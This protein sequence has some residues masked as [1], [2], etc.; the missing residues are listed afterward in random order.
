MINQV[1]S[2]CQ[3]SRVVFMINPTINSWNFQKH[4]K[5]HMWAVKF[6]IKISLVLRTREILIGNFTAH[7]WD[8]FVFLEIPLVNSEIS[9]KIY[10]IFKRFS[11]FWKMTNLKFR[12][13]SYLEYCLKLWSTRFSCIMSNKSFISYR[14]YKFE[15]RSEGSLMN[16]T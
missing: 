2:N 1:K 11:N 14:W 12:C 4:S 6:P 3:L 16:P 13:L 8:F 9:N 7:V 15:I 10:L 5:S